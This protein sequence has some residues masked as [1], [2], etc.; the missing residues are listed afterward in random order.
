MRSRLS[1][2]PVCPS[3]SQTGSTFAPYQPTHHKACH[4]PRQHSM[5]SRTWLGGSGG[6]WWKRELLLPN[7]SEFLKDI[8]FPTNMG[9]LRVGNEMQ[10]VSLHR[11]HTCTIPMLP[12]GAG[13]RHERD[14]ERVHLRTTVQDWLSTPL[15]PTGSRNPDCREVKGEHKIQKPSSFLPLSWYSTTWHL[16]DVSH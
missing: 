3:V 10:S 6:A 15:M 5:C 1:L 11:K 9:V 2:Q 14:A 8:R 4:A 13:K 12:L 7:F 16:N